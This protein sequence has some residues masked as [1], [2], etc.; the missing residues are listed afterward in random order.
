MCPPFSLPHPVASLLWT[1][2]VRCLYKSPVCALSE[3][4][5]PS[6]R[7]R[8]FSP[9]IGSVLGLRARAAQESESGAFPPAVSPGM[10]PLATSPFFSHGTSH[11]AGVTI[12]FDRFPGKVIDY[13]SDTDGHW[14]MVIVDINDEKLFL[15]CVYGGKQNI[16]LRLSFIQSFYF[17]F[18]HLILSTKNRQKTKHITQIQNLS[19]YPYK[20]SD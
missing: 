6:W 13:S 17:D 2:G 19:D 15:I 12:L 1:W 3:L 18:K 7:V 20:Q 10:A 9:P 8:G 16:H 14:S 5:S 11:S 4:H